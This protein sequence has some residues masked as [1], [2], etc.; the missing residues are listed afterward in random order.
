MSGQ[1]RAK[2]RPV[3]Q[4]TDNV[5]TWWGKTFV[6]V[7]KT[8]V[9]TWKGALVLM[10]VAGSAAAFIWKTKL[11]DYSS[12]EAAPASTLYFNPAS[13]TTTAGS[14]FNLAATINPGS[15]AVSAVELHVTFDQTKLRLDSITAGA[16]FSLELMAANINNTNGTAAIA[17]GVPL[18][19]PSM[20]TTSTV[21]T[22]AFTALSTATN[23][24]VAF[25][26]TSIAAADGESGNVI[27]TRTSGTVTVNA[28]DAT[29]PTGGSVSYTN[30]YLAVTSVALTVGDGTDA[31]GINTGSRLVQR[32]SATLTGGTCGAYGTFATVTP[33]GT[34]PNFTDATVTSG[35]CYQYQYLVSDTLGNQ[36]T[37]TTTNAAKIDTAA[38]TGG[39]VT[40]TDGYFTTASVAI[41]AGDGTDTVSGINTAT[42]TTQRR[43]ATLSAGTCGTYGSYATITPTGTYP[44]FTDATVTTG[45]CYQYQYRVSDTAG[46]QATYTT[47]NAAKVDTAAPSGGSISYVDGYRSVRSV[48]LTAADSTDAVSGLNSGSQTV[49]RRSAT[50]SGGSCGTYGSYATITPTGTYPNFTDATVTTGNC[51]QYRFQISDNAGNQ[52]TYTST[53][54][55]KMSYQSDISLSGAV[56]IFD[57][58]LLHSNFGNTTCGNVADIVTNCSVDI[59]DFNQLHAEYGSSV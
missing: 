22:F 51:Y 54:A 42:R 30:G 3:D 58:S 45:N 36:A 4:L 37:Y 9:A 15:N 44:N 32:R 29:A 59:F 40:Y 38:P 7:R 53:N 16:S 23:S 35:N 39:S 55:A 26:T 12:V 57:Y 1:G 34:Y 5:T 18:G 14:T 11:E 2:G 10:F 17:L 52:A 31:S 25:A 47:T 48:A 46:N 33:T 49:Q 6:Y 19:S 50:L 24:P 27:T 20:T 21:A 13:T 8:E 56:D 43:S 28:A 41:T